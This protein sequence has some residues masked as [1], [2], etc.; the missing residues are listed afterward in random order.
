MHP[1]K[2]NSL[3][4]KILLLLFVIVLIKYD[5]SAQTLRWFKGNLHTHTINSDGNS[6]PNTVVQWYKEDGYNF[7]VLTDHNFLTKTEGLN[8]IFSAEGK[9]IVIP[10]EEITDRL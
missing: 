8:Q 5:V 4:K 7:C 6:S 9:F 3:I 1:K 2:N 10:G